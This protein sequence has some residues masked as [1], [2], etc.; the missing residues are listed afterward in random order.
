MAAAAAAA[1]ATTLASTAAAAAVAAAV[2]GCTRAQTLHARAPWP[3]CTRTVAA[4]LLGGPRLGAVARRCDCAGQ[5]SPRPARKNDRFCCPWR[6]C[7]RREEAARD[8]AGGTRGT[9]QSVQEARIHRGKR[10]GV[11]GSGGRGRG[12]GRVSGFSGGRVARLN[13]VGCSVSASRSGARQARGGWA[14]TLRD[15]GSARVHVAAPREGSL[16]RAPEF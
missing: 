8:L 1:A 13:W 3:R 2:V 16:R 12:L 15:C 6:S 9:W 14:H 10:R 11:R 7:V 5:P 4:H